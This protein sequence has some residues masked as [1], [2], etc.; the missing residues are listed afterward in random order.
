[1]SVDVTL[2]ISAP[3]R[4][5]EI[6]QLLKIL[7]LVCLLYVLDLQIGFRVAYALLAIDS[8]RVMSSCDPPAPWTVAP[9]Y[10][11]KLTSSTSKP[12]MEIV[13]ATL[14][15]VRSNQTAY[16]SH[17]GQGSKKESASR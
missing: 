2:H 17:E 12:S 16:V 11:K 8:L 14:A 10:M 6:T 9:K 4:S 1:M 5:I 7:S 3:Y 15:F 13:L